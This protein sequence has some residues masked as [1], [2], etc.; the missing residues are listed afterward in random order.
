M[1]AISFFFA[2]IL[3]L[4]VFP[5]PVAAGGPWRGKIIDM[6]TKEPIEGAVVLAVWKRVYRTPTGDSS[7]FYVAKEVLTDK[8]G[9]FEIPAYTPINLLPIISYM[10]GPEFTIFKPRYLSLSGEYLEEN[11]LD[12][13]VELRKSGK[14]FRLAP[15]IIELPK[16]ETREERL[17]AQSD[18]LPLGGVPDEKMP[19]LLNLINAERKSL[20]L[21]PVHV[22]GGNKK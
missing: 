13:A 8:E 12:K 1:R 16:L 2:I 5:A 20:G 19:V 14:V 9:R 18:A 17:E 3:I 22:R 15:G 11:V 7:Y 6:G 21:D 10:R 4:A